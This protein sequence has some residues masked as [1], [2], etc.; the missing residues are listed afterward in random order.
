MAFKKLKEATHLLLH[1]PNTE[2]Q[3]LR[4]SEKPQAILRELFDALK[5]VAKTAGVKLS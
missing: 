3:R 4:E 5:D 1:L 2:L